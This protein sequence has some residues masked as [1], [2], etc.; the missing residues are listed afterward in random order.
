MQNSSEHNPNRDA[1]L[2]RAPSA[3]LDLIPGINHTVAF[4]KDWVVID[5]ESAEGNM[6]IESHVEAAAQGHSEAFV[7]RHS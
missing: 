4:R 2:I 6:I 1:H 5:L 3:E 7:S